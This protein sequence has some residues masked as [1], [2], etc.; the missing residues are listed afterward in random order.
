MADHINP[1]ASG[2]QGKAEQ[3][4]N[5]DKGTEYAEQGTDTPLGDGERRMS[6]A[7][8]GIKPEKKENAWLAHVKRG[9][10][11]PSKARLWGMM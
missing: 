11:L 1:S 6:L 9:R 7:E 4:Y 2:P 3:A 5:N 8:Q 10:P